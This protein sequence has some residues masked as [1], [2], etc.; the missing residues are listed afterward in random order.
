MRT[1]N[2]NI[3]KMSKESRLQQ[4]AKLHFYYCAHKRLTDVFR[5]IGKDFNPIKTLIIVLFETGEKTIESN[6]CKVVVLPIGDDTNLMPSEKYVSEMA[7]GNG[8][9]NEVKNE[10]FR[11][12]SL[13]KKMK[14][15]GGNDDSAASK[16]IRSG[17]SG[18][19]KNLEIDTK[20]KISDN[21]Q[22]VI[23]VCQN[24]LSRSPR[25]TEIFAEIM[26]EMRIPCYIDNERSCPVVYA[27]RTI[28][29][30]V[31]GSHRKPKNTDPDASTQPTEN[32]L[33]FARRL[34]SHL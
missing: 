20:S 10:D 16:K 3:P 11:D 18:I 29:Q 26:F 7:V 13:K 6:G 34:T 12:A 28:Q 23:F 14:T 8:V 4:T 21:F 31:I 1:T 33:L 24:G 27:D 17:L 32:E 25:A 5:N 30:K 19:L 15:F 22:K 9:G 2:K